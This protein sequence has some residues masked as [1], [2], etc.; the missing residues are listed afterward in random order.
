MF[1]CGAK[2]VGKKWALTCV[3]IVCI[4]RTFALLLLSGFSHNQLLEKHLRKFVNKEKCSQGI[5][6]SGCGIWTPQKGYGIL[7]LFFS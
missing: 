3:P 4:E 5:I 1:I 2:P 7:L 6:S